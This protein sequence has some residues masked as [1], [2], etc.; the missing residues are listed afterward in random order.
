MNDFLLYFT[1]LETATDPPSSWGMDNFPSGKY[2][3]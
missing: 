2:I 3:S 1:E